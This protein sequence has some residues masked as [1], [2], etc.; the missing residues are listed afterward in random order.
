MPRGHR[1]TATK[2]RR[3]VL[4]AEADRIAMR[5]I[6]DFFGVYALVLPQVPAPQGLRQPDGHVLRP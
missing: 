5:D 2:P 3:V 1:P 4:R 6:V